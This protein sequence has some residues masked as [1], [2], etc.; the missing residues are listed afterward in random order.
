MK[1]EFLRRIYP[2]PPVQESELAEIAKVHHSLSFAR[3]EVLLAEGA[4]ANA[5]YLVREGYVREWVRGVDGGEI[6][7]RIFG[8]GALVL[9]PASLFQ[10]IP[11]RTNLETV[12]EGMAYRVSYDDFQM[13][14]H[15]FEGVRE[16]GRGWMS[17]ELFLL[18][19]RTID[20]LTLSATERYRTLLQ[21]EPDLLA[22]TP[23]KHVASYLGVTDTSLSRIRK[24]L[25]RGG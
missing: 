19:Q 24:E 22:H 25:A 11:S 10:R 23:L 17:N 2:F 7:C 1:T 9:E 16:W 15:R 5:Y 18:R 21:T 13:L 14:F 12:S 20:M 6:T 8:P 4:Q 3:N